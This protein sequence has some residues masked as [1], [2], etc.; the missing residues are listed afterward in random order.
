MVLAF[1]FFLFGS[2]SNCIVIVVGIYAKFLASTCEC[3]VR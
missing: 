1:F 2:M 3:D